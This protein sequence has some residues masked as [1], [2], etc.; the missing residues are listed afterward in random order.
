[1]PFQSFV[2]IMEAVAAHDA[3]A[4]LQASGE[5]FE[6]GFDPLRYGSGLCSIL[7]VLRCMRSGLDVSGVFGY[8]AQE[9]EVLS[10]IAARCSNE[11]LSAM[12]RIVTRMVQELRFSENE[13]A[14]F[15][16]A[17]LDLVAIHQRPS[18]AAA[19]KSISSAGQDAPDEKKNV[20][21]EAGAQRTPSKETVRAQD[22]QEAWQLLMR[23]CQRLKQYLF[24]K[25]Q[26]ARISFA[27][28]EILLEYRGA[29]QD[30]AGLLPDEKDM[31]YLRER[32]AMVYEHKAGVRLVENIENDEPLP[33]E[34]PPTEADVLKAEEDELETMHPVVQQLCEI[35]YGQIVEKENDNA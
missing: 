33:D 30:V 15:E 10:K 4:L 3:A 6:K 19:L 1:M 32:L 20:I 9:I 31:L 27:E 11:Q 35:F 21:F 26:G 29:I 5:V 28:N 2:R 7:H 23:D 25:L 17:L 16:M 14:C 22:I 8:S 12:F 34:E 24:R 18:L 13:R